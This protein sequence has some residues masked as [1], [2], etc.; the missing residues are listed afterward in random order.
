MVSRNLR[1]PRRSPSC[2][3]IVS[4]SSQW[5]PVRVS[6]WGEM[7]VHFMAGSRDSTRAPACAQG[8]RQWSAYHDGCGVAQWVGHTETSTMCHL[9]QGGIFGACGAAAEKDV[10]L[11][12]TNKNPGTRA[13][14]QESGVQARTLMTGGWWCPCAPCVL[15]YS[16]PRPRK[17]YTLI[18]ACATRTGQVRRKRAGRSVKQAT[19]GL[20]RGCCTEEPAR[21]TRGAVPHAASPIPRF[22]GF[23]PGA[24]RVRPALALPKQRPAAGASRC[25]PTL[26]HSQEI[27]R[28]VNPSRGRRLYSNRAESCVVTA[29]CATVPLP[30]LPY[31][32]TAAQCSSSK[33]LSPRFHAPSRSRR[34]FS[35]ANA[36]GAYK[37]KYHTALNLPRPLRSCRE[38]ACGEIERP[39]RKTYR[40]FVERSAAA[41]VVSTRALRAAA[42]SSRSGWW[43][44]AGVS[45]CC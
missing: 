16:E 33:C 1:H 34:L 35:S 7:G 21:R 30:L 23:A 18:D 38:L 26:P 12:G 29:S 40:C 28:L 17:Q 42:G 27:A 45:A 36:P 10:V 13:L 2:C 24:K 4:T 25:R 14:A 32:F 6:A 5:G 15:Q 44:H 19:D 8:R 3:V 41:A 11:S 39:I 20:A 43:Q 37:A 22:I 31:R 9:A